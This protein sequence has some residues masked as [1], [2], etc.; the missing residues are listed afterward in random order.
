MRGGGG[1]HHSRPHSGL[2]CL[3]LLVAP[4][5]LQRRSRDL[6]VHGSPPGSLLL[7]ALCE[8]WRR[9]EMKV[10]AFCALSLASKQEETWLSSCHSAKEPVCKQGKSIRFE[11]RR[12]GGRGPPSSAPAWSQPTWDA[13]SAETATPTGGLQAS[14]TL[15]EQGGGGPDCPWNHASHLISAPRKQLTSSKTNGSGGQEHCPAVLSRCS[16]LS[17]QEQK[18]RE[19]ATSCLPGYLRGLSLSREHSL[20]GWASL[21]N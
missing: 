2:A 20:S 19:A 3:T 4:G 7:S 14:D 5:D 8:S 17:K 10:G 16:E 15:L 18:L 12:G 6:R 9:G 13:R 11:V 21:S 1:W